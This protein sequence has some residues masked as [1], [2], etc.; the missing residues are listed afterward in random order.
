MIRRSPR[1]HPDVNTDIKAEYMNIVNDMREN[2]IAV[3]YCKSVKSRAKKVNNMFKKF[4]DQRELIEKLAL[5]FQIQKEQEFCGTLYSLE[6][7]QMRK[8]KEYSEEI[9]KGN[10]PMYL[11]TQFDTIFKRLHKKNMKYFRSKIDALSPIYLCDELIYAV[12]SYM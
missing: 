10:M 5:S 3:K 6:M 9:A 1:L 8:K 4:L 7:F 2:A 11:S 12:Y